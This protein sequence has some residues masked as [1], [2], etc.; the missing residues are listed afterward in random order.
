MSERP[1][2]QINDIN[3]LYFEGTAAGELRVR[4]CRRCDT[5]F[6]FAHA[7][8]PHCWSDDLGWERVSGQGRVTHVS[9]VYQA[10]SAAFVKDVPYVLAL[11]ELECGVRMMS[12][13]VDCDPETVHIGMAVTVTF[14][15]RGEIS[16]PMFRRGS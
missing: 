10:P 13:I 1:V 9:V 15:R 3:R 4:H 14:E 11:I 7:W 16:L 8:C 2:P 5:R 6:R 12:N